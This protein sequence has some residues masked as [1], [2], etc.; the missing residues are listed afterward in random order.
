MSESDHHAEVKDDIENGKQEQGL[1]NA[2]GNREIE[3]EDIED[4]EDIEEKV[5]LVSDEV[6]REVEK[7]ENSQDIKDTMEVKGPTKDEDQLG[8]I[9]GKRKVDESNDADLIANHYNKIRPLNVSRRSNSSI[10]NLRNFNNWLKGVLISEHCNKSRARCVLDLACG[11]GG[12][13]P[14]WKHTRID[15]LI[16]IDIAELSIEEARKRYSQMRPR[17]DAEYFALDAFHKS[18]SNVINRDQIFDLISCQFAYHY[19]FETEES[20]KHSI[21]EVAKQLRAG[22]RFIGT[23]P[24]F[25]EIRNRLGEKKT[26][27]NAIF[28]LSLDDGNDV[29]PGYGKRYSFD[30]AE[31]IDSCPEY[32]IPMPLLEALAEE[33][34]LELE[35]TLPFKDFFLKYSQ[36]H[37]DSLQRMNVIDRDDNLKLTLDELEVAELYLAFSFI[38]RETNT[39]NAV[40]K[41]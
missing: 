14:K 29:Q 4:V 26:I 5:E 1:T 24:N 21:A 10:I 7:V 15:R 23:I 3:K 18:W 8:K 16:G 31:A 35:S 12:D 40:N 36:A 30:L 41:G 9:A 2:Q 37:H 33:V 38:K 22:G 13:L 11:K 25:S 6:E 20:A 28:S 19:S 17:F 27:N 34:G 32:F 39:A